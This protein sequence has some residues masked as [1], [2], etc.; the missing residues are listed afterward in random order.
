VKAQSSRDKLQLGD[1]P[2]GLPRAKQA[3]ARILAQPAL[4]KAL[5]KAMLSED[6]NLRWRAADTARRVTER[7]PELLA[8]HAEALIG[9][10]SESAADNWRTRAHLGLVV[11]RVARSRA[12]RIRAA[13]LLMP[14]YYDPSNVVRA[15]AIEGL[16]ILAR[17]E[18][19]LRSQFEALAEE[20][21][22]A[23]T[24]AMKNRAEHGLARLGSE[25]RTRIGA[26]PRG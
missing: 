3:S 25:K 2:W 23:G 6:E 13:G 26:G 9:R 4:I 10:F 22:V 5:V 12:Q 15:T 24:L 20:A 1:G 21:L 11:A 14:L 8:P 7:Q 16:G 18:P 19:S 17:C